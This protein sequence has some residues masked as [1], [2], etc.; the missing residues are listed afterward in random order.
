MQFLLIGEGA[1]SPLPQFQGR[2][3][4]LQLEREL[5][6]GKANR[7]IRLLDKFHPHM[8]QGVFPNLQ[9]ANALFQEIA[10]AIKDSRGPATQNIIDVRGKDP[11]RLLHSI[12]D[13]V[14]ARAQ[15]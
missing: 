1:L 7:E 5:S 13:A 6:L 4:K 14:E 11:R 10:G 3:H 2:V 9:W 15:G 12:V 8:H